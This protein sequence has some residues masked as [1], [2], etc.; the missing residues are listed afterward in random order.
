MVLAA[1]LISSLAAPEGV[2]ACLEADAAGGEKVVLWSLETHDYFIVREGNNGP[3]V[4]S[5]DGSRLAFTAYEGERAVIQVAE[6]DG[7]RANA[8]ALPNR[9]DVNTTPRWSHDG[10]RLAYV[11]G[12]GADQRIV[13]Y[14]FDTGKETEWGGDATGLMRPVWLQGEAILAMMAERRAARGIENDETSMLTITDA[15]IILAI[16]AVPASGGL[17]TD[18]FLV[19]KEHAV[20]FPPDVMPSSAPYVEWAVEPEPKGRRF[21]FESNDGGDRE[22][23]VINSKGG[24]DLSNHRAADWNPVWSIDGKWIAFESFRTGKRGIF[25][26][27]RDTIRISAVAASDEHNNWAP[28]WSPDDDWI[29]HVSDRLGIPQLY[30]TA[31][32]GEESEV[33]TD[34]AHGAFAPAWQPEE[35][36]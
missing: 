11:A 12:K 22:I 8:K 3:P 14:N 18:I 9:Y 30:V 2:I 24:F 32:N 34:F 36:D 17:S 4:W 25:R 33:V 7:L 6:W 20:A 29:V 13:V 31:A 16:G 15:G 35:D 21:A 23:F 26:V 1:F 5:P 10:S 19:T 28:S 27:Y